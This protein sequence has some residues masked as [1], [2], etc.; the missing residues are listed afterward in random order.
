MVNGAGLG[1]GLGLGLE[2]GGGGGLLRNQGIEKF[3]IFLL[4]LVKA[5]WCERRRGKWGM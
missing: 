1:L 2:G 5:G 4:Y 3:R